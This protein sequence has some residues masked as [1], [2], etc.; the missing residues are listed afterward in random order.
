[1]SDNRSLHVEL[2]AGQSVSLDNGRIVVQLESKTGKVAQLKIT[3]P[4]D[5]SIQRPGVPVI[6]GAAQ[7]RMG[8]NRIAG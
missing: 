5:V 8:I 7:A 1:M 4:S 6:S 3:A 2:R